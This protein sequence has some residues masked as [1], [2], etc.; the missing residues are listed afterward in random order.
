MNKEQIKAKAVLGLPLSDRER[1][2]YLLL[3]A[4][5]EEYKAFLN[6]EKGGKIN[7]SN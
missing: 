6:W 4:S 3:L 7:E 5:D 1:A 2:I